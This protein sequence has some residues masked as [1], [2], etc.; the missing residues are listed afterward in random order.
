MRFATLTSIFLLGL[1]AK[2]DVINCSFTEPFIRTQ[3]SMSQ[4]SLTTKFDGDDAVSVIKGVSFQIKGPGLFELMDSNK[5]VL[6]E[7]IL[8][9][10]GS[11]GMSDII[12]PYTVK[13]FS[14]GGDAILWGGCESNFLKRKNP[15]R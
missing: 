12:Y 2:A 8:D 15:N 1:S 4:N 13:Y 9:N 11:D 14:A 10:K 7:L 3:Y 5:K 6:M